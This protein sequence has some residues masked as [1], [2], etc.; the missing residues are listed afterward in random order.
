M[1]IKQTV[2]IVWVLY[3]HSENVHEYNSALCHIAFIY[4]DANSRNGEFGLDFWY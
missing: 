3:I 1:N 4:L 2:F